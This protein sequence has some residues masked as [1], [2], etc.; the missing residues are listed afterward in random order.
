MPAQTFDPVLPD[1]CAIGRESFSS[2]EW[3]VIAIGARDGSVPLPWSPFGRSILKL[4]GVDDGPQPLG[5]CCLEALRRM[6][7]NARRHGW[8]VPT[9]EVGA[10]LKGGWSEAQLETLIDSVSL[11]APCM[12][13]WRA[14][15]IDRGGGRPERRSQAPLR[16]ET[17][18]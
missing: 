1:G 5:S 12:G 7:S 3:L 6:A 11:G 13:E 10:F 17:L 8:G 2:L 9:A 16:M 4:F 18:S 14:C 15:N